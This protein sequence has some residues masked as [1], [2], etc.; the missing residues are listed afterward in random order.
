MTMANQSAL[1]FGV[2]AGLALPFGDLGDF[3]KLGFDV[4][5]SAGFMLPQFPLSFRADLAWN[6]FAGKNVSAN[7]GG[8][9]FETGSTRIISGSINA[10]YE[11]PVAPTGAQPSVV[12]PYI[13]GGIGLYNT[14]TGEGRDNEG[15]TIPSTSATDFGI[16]VGGGIMFRL[17]G[18]TAFTEARLQNVFVTGG[19]LRFIPVN[20][21]LMFG[22]R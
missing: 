5:G 21:G 2:A 12:R 10:I 11:F 13:I 22:G 7:V 9:A 14:R 8:T 18:L 19:S 17:S 20:F 15:T 16:N 4:Q 6:Q 1:T 3:A